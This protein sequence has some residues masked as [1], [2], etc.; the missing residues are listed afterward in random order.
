MSPRLL[1][2]SLLLSVCA[3]PS[4]HLSPAPS[5]FSPSWLAASTGEGPSPPPPPSPLLSAP[6]SHSSG[7]HLSPLLFSS[8]HPHLLHICPDL[9]LIPPLGAPIS[10]PLG[11]TPF[12]EGS[13][14]FLFPMYPLPCSLPAL[15]RAA[16]TSSPPF[17]AGPASHP[18]ACATPQQAQLPVATASPPARMPLS[19]PAALWTWLASPPQPRKSHPHHPPVGVKTCSM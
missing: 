17:P 19:L 15:S 3:R 2:T 4:S 12:L 14:P 1:P 13:L 5:T 6:P 16:T 7:L 10:P 18:K 9:T 8:M 11:L